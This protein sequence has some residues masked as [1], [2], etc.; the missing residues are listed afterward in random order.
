MDFF[1]AVVKIVPVLKKL[2][3]SLGNITRIFRYWQGLIFEG[4]IF[5]LTNLKVFY[6]RLVILVLKYFNFWTFF[7]F[8]CESLKEVIVILKLLSSVGLQSEVCSYRHGFLLTCIISYYS[9][10]IYLTYFT[11]VFLLQII[12]T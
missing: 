10:E 2:T 7:E 6:G 12:K 11:I 1:C 4:K 8:S 3:I 5:A 9:N